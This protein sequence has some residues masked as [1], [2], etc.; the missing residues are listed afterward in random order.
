MAKSQTQ[1]ATEQQQ[2]QSLDRSEP[3]ITSG[4]SNPQNHSRLKIQNHAGD[5]EVDCLGGKQEISTPHD[6]LPYSKEKYVTRG[7]GNL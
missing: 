7:Q 6:S 4:G 1:Q 3:I 5:G 2:S